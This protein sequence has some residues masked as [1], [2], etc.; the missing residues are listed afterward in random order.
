MTGGKDTGGS[1]SAELLAAD[2]YRDFVT[3]ML[4]NATSVAIGIGEAA[5]ADKGVVLREIGDSVELRDQAARALI[6]IIGNGGEVTYQ[7]GPVSVRLNG[8]L[9]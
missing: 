4:A 9:T 8:Y 6:N 5:V 2:E 7:T 1:A 3:I